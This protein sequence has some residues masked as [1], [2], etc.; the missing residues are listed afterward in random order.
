[1]FCESGDINETSENSGGRISGVGGRLINGRVYNRY[2]NVTIN[3][4]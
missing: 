4:N 3:V 2:F 1:M